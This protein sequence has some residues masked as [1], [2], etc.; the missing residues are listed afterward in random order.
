MPVFTNFDLTINKEKVLKIMGCSPESGIYQKTAQLYDCLLES[1][2]DDLNPTGVY[3]FID[4]PPTL[5][6]QE[7]ANCSQIVLCF[8]TLGEK[9]SLKINEYFAENR[10]WEAMLLEVMADQILFKIS[11]R[12]FCQVLSE[13]RKKGWNL[14]E[15]LEPGTGTIPLDIQ[16]EIFDNLN[17]MEINVSLNSA[18]VFSPLKSLAFFCGAGKDVSPNA[19]G[20]DCAKC[21]MKNCLFNM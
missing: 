15:K 13:A 21:G 3:K 17:L 8:L 5:K 2:K 20:H 4:I 10:L 1:I 19:K 18:F 11:D 7:I 16:K 14:T 6:F 12:L 9:I